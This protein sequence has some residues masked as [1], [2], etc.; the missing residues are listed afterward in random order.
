MPTTQ[1]FEFLVEGVDGVPFTTYG[2]RSLCG[3]IV[4][5]KI[6]A[7]AGVR[8][9]IRVK[10]QIPFPPPN[11]ALSSGQSRYKPGA[12]TRQVEGVGEGDAM[13]HGSSDATAEA[14]KEIL[15]LAMVY[16]DGNEKAE[17]SKLIVVDPESRKYKAEGYL[18]DGRYSLA[19]D[20]APQTGSSL[21]IMAVMSV[22]PWVFTE[23]GIDVLMSRMDIS[24]ADPYIPSTAM[25]QEVVVLTQEM[26]ND[27]LHAGAESK[28]GEIEVKI[29][30]VLHDGD[31]RP[32]LY[33][34]RSEEETPKEDDG[35]THDVTI[36]QNQAQRVTMASVK[37]RRYQ[38]DE[39]F[40]CKAKFQYMDI[41]KLV[42]L[43]LCNTTGEPVDHRQNAVDSRLAT[44]LPSSREA[45]A[46]QLKRARGFEGKAGKR[47]ESEL[48]RSSSSEEEESASDK[49]SDSD[50]PRR[51]H[52][53]AIR[54]R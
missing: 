43:G 34:K 15:Y 41:A 16:M 29:L 42:N 22:S 44:L 20:T 28:V 50:V 5:T 39:E 19:N 45:R 2:T 37:Y 32:D 13:G 10:P 4:S 11:D 36:D 38:P 7:K 9:H 30:R 21:G 26:N 31:V 6:Q 35:R 23:R 40:L 25:E 51:K 24:T 49:T 8:F 18:L 27:N 12:S 54:R 53:G 48:A 52:R 3:R 17:A 33:W 1:G 47:R 46:G 14:E